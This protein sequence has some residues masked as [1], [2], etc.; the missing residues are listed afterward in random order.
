MPW[1]LDLLLDHIQICQD[2]PAPLTNVYTFVRAYSAAKTALI[3][4]NNLCIHDSVLSLVN[5][6]VL[7]RVSSRQRP[8]F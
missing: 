3:C 5:L 8:R 1:S 2:L 6:R 4:C 7:K